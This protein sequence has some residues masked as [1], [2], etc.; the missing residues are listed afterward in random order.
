[1]LIRKI[2]VTLVLAT[3]FAGFQVMA[4]DIE[5]G[6]FGGGSYYLGELNP[7]RQFFF[8][9]PAFGVQARI[10]VDDRWSVKLGGYKATIAGDD[11]VR[12][13]DE[14]RNLR[15]TS[16]LTEFSAV[17]ELNYMDYFIGSANHFFTP[18]LYA[19]PG[20]FHFN[21]K[22]EYNG[23]M[24]SLQ[25][26]G[27]EGQTIGLKKKYNLF[28]FAAVF[29][30]GVKYSLSS[31]LGLT[32]DWGLRKAFTDYLDDISGNYADFSNSPGL[33]NDPTLVLSDPSQVK[34]LPGMQRGNPENN[35]W[36]SMAG[37]TIIY[38]FT[39]GEKSNCKDFE[40]S[41]NK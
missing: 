34:H 35:D 1:M 37:L 2:N 21:P 27:T 41:N 29:G 20:V 23:S 16:S 8:T 18:Y 14:L 10:N 17:L 19:G 38:R 33:V 40:H 3:V 30:F 15:F 36:Y 7:D 28:G 9:K 4:Q 11:A 31:R 24:I 39:I 5:F 13:A 25:E 12:K 26:I 6:V 32:L 22:A